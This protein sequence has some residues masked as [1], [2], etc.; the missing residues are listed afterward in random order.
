MKFIDVEKV[1]KKHPQLNRED[2]ASIQEWLKKQSHLPKLTDLYIALFLHSSNFSVEAAKTRLEIF[3]TFRTKLPQFFANRDVLREDIQFHYHVFGFYPLPGLT[4]Q[5]RKVFFFK[6]LKPDFFNLKMMLRICLLTPEPSVFETG[7]LDGIVYVFDMS[8]ARLSHLAQVNLS[9]LNQVLTLT[10]EGYPTKVSQILFI[11]P[12]P[13][14]AQVLGVIKPFL[15][16]DLR[17]GIKVYA[18]VKDISESV[19]VEMLPSDYEGGKAGSLQKISEN[20]WD[21]LK[22]HRDYFLDDERL[23]RADLS[24]RPSKSAR[25]TRADEI[26]G[27]QGNFKRLDID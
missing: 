21:Y 1:Y 23:L 24:K 19:P 4:P 15:R 13:F 10:Q 3:F 9:E 17:E 6:I 8:N 5:G 22:D 20:Y 7:P 11:N 27:V 12:V 2:V 25:N 16:P 18:D 26:F 14:T